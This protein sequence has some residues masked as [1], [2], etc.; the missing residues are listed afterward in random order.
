MTVDNTN[1]EEDGED[2]NAGD[3]HPVRDMLHSW[4]LCIMI[5][6][7][8]LAWSTTHR[9][10]LALAATLVTPCLAILQGALGILSFRLH[11]GD[12]PLPRSPSH[13]VVVVHPDDY[14]ETKQSD[15]HDLLQRAAQEPP[16]RL[17]VIG[18]SLAIGVGQSKSSTPIMPEIIARTLSKKLDGRAVY[19]TCH[20]APGASTG[21]IA[22]ELERGVDYLQKD[23][24]DHE[25]DDDEDESDVDDDAIAPKRSN[26]TCETDDS[27]SDESF[28]S[29]NNTGMTTYGCNKGDSATQ[30]R[31][32]N[33]RA[34]EKRQWK[35]RLAQHRKRFNPHK[36]GPYDVVVILTGSNDLKSAFF[37]FLL[38]GEDA[39]FRRQA[40]LRGGSYG[41]E[42]RRLLE[43]LEQRM[44]TQFQNLR[45]SVIHSV[46]AATERIQESIEETM[47]RI[48]PGSSSKLNGFRLTRGDSIKAIHTEATHHKAA[49]SNGTR[50][51]RGA[52]KDLT[53][54]SMEN[55]RQLPL[56][57]LPGMPSRVLPIF[58]QV[59]LRWLSVPIVDIMDSH[60]KMVAQS[61][62]G[63]LLFVKAPGV[64]ELSDYE[65]GIGSIWEDRMAEN[66]LLSLKD[67]GKR[68]KHVIEERMHLYFHDRG[69]SA[70]EA[71]AKAN[72]IPWRRFFPKATIPPCHD[73]FSVD[74]IHPNEAGYDFW[75]RYIANSIVD[76]L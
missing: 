10:A 38:S 59:P 37:P 1:R 31:A 51:R 20:G 35:D 4:L 67:I 44:T 39:E 50:R 62:P 25:Q 75:G 74:K 76:E 23:I 49:H 32:P 57:V 24:V 26:S 33:I 8:V 22:R 12:A 52:D 45:A 69:Q 41:M 58:R 64:D 47:E 36:L 7:G 28:S 5:P 72:S 2:S 9:P 61:H 19:W 73:V 68:D 6:A 55:G 14:E 17:L 29:G 63:N 18:D 13:G 21:W 65:S 3:G 60:K 66:T 56:I 34:E 30:R 43:T 48:A 11:F 16:V 46:E 70:A 71:I 27:S 40:K 15:A 54:S 53:K 42:L